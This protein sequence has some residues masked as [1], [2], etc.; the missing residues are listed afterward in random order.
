M[1][2]LVT[3]GTGFI[4]RALVTSLLARGDQV[5][6]LTRNPESARLGLS[7]QVICIQSLEHSPAVDVVVNLAGEPLFA[8]RWNAA[9]KQQFRDSRIGTT[10]ALLD[11][12]RHSSPKVLLSGSAIGYYGD[13]GDQAVDEHAPPA[14]DFAS[15]LVQDW[16]NTALE[17]TDDGIRVC[18]LRTG[19]V[20]GKDGG[21]LKQL[22][23]L[24]RSGL[25]GA[26]GSGRQ[27]MSWIHLADMVGLIE[28]CVHHDISGPMNCTAPN[29]VTNRE[30]SRLLGEAVHR[31][32][33]LRTP[34][35]ILKLAVG[36]SAYMLL[37]GQKVLP[38]L[39]RK[40][41]YDF[42]FSRLEDA[43]RDVI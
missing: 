30:F 21:F 19:L 41:G 36:E 15:Q 18:L 32:A 34:A 42:S 8:K 9:R 13:K 27:W 40:T 24:Y 35:S 6:V 29:P 2:Y 12:M 39:A 25:G 5:T 28:H 38:V 31:P 43:L 20:V 37:T 33:I 14:T 11:W 17:A 4:G 1:H 16:E 22:V 3:G 7:P 26:L 10:R 23:P